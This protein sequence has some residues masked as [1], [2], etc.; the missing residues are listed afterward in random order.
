MILSDKSLTRLVESDNLVCNGI[1][2]NI[3][4]ASIDLRLNEDITLPPLTLMLGSTI[5]YINM[6][7]KYA[8]RV[9]GK[10]SWGRL[11]LMIHVSAGFI[12]PGFHGNITLELF[13]CSTKGLQLKRGMNICQMCVEELDSVPEYVYGECH[14]HYQ[15]Q[16]GVTESVLKEWSKE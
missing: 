9:E 16:I 11:G 2:Y 4:P 13:N 14:N 6:P 10:S 12:D 8:G 3:Q 1:M 7:I 5:E 15:G